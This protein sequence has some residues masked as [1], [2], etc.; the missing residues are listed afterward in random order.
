[1][2]HKIIRFEKPATGINSINLDL[3]C[4]LSPGLTVRQY[5]GD[6]DGNSRL[7]EDDLN[8]YL[9]ILEVAQTQDIFFPILD[10][11]VNQILD[12]G[13]HSILE[14]LIDEEKNDK[15]KGR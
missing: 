6:F 5:P 14:E 2:D 10:L 4:R 9:Q 13:D 1:M 15:P 7:T 12:N 3:E 8:V 11:N